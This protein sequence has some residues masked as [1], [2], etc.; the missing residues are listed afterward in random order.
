MEFR[1]WRRG[2]SILT[3][4]PS[5]VDPQKRSANSRAQKILTDIFTAFS[6]L[7]RNPGDAPLIRRA[8][9][10]ATEA[11]RVVWR[12]EVI[13]DALTLGWI[14]T[15]RIQNPLMLSHNPREPTRSLRSHRA[16]STAF[17]SRAPLAII[18]SAVAKASVSRTSRPGYCGYGFFSTISFLS[19]P[20]NA[21]RSSFSFWPTLN[22]S[23]EA[24]R[25]LAAAS[26]SASVIPSP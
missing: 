7:H 22:L 4:F 6:R 16:R 15:Q 8:K 2:I 24:T 19:P 23:S 13:T 11:T 21:K 26:H 9:P 1:S 18:L 20:T 5:R 14:M 17:F 25:C 10:G 12:A 3:N